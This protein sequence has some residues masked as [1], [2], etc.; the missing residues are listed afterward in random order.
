MIVHEVL[1]NLILHADAPG[2]APNYVRD[3]DLPGLGPT[4]T[5]DCDN[6][7]AEHGLEHHEAVAAVASGLHAC[8]LAQMHTNEIVDRR[9]RFPYDPYDVG[10]GG[11]GF[12]MELGCEC[13]GCDAC[14]PPLGDSEDSEYSEDE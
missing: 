3:C 14:L 10:C 1:C 13:D 4:P 5:P 6:E 11:T 7:N 2:P 12:S 8:S 9:F